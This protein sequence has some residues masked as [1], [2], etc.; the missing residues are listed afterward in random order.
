MRLFGSLLQEPRLAARILAKSPTATTLSLVSIAL[1]IGITTAMFSFV[2]AAYLRP[3]PF[4]QPSEILQLE[5][6]GDNGRSFPYTWPDY[7]DAAATTE[8]DELELAAS[9]VV[10]MGMEDS[11]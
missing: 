2:D 4:E 11:G 7:Q 3:M 6:R 5:S 8:L 9:P 10:P 1:G